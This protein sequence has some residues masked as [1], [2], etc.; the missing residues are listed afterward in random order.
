MIRRALVVLIIS[1]MLEKN[2]EYPYAYSFELV[3]VSEVC[4]TKELK[5]L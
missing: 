2:I 3:K 1:K 4:R 5:Y